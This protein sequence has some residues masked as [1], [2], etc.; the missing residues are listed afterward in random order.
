MITYY[1]FAY[2]CLNMLHIFY[3]LCILNF[4]LYYLKITMYCLDFPYVITLFHVFFLF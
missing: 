4:I 2:F 1:F 3:Y